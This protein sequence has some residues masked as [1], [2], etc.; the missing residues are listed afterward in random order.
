MKSSYMKYLD[1]LKEEGR[2]KRLG[3]V[4]RNVEA[5]YAALQSGMFEV[6]QFQVDPT[7]DLL[8][9]DFDTE[10]STTVAQL[11]GTADTMRTRLYEY[12]KEYNIA[13]VIVEK[14]SDKPSKFSRM[15]QMH[16]ALTRPGVVSILSNASTIE[17][18]ARDLHYLSASDE[19]KDFTLELIKPEADEENISDN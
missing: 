7:M 14:E 19:E 3:L 16:F 15:Q 2:I 11:L 1:Q 6:L 12:C 4:C 10:D 9:A 13:I 18:F 17:D 8:P 5:A